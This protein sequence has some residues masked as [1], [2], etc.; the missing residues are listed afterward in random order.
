MNHIK[1]NSTV[2]YMKVSKQWSEYYSAEVL[3]KSSS[4]GSGQ[5]ER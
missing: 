4:N 5:T 1:N 3:G 2:N